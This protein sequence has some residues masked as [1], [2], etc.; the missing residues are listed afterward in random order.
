MLRLCYSCHDSFPSSDTNTQQIFWTLL[1]VSRLGVEI[2]LFVPSVQPADPS[3]PRAGIARYYGADARDLPHGF[4]LKV[5]RRRPAGSALAKGWFDWQAARHLARAS[6]DLVWTR[7]VLTVVSCIRAGLD[8]VFETYRPDLAKATRFALWRRAVIGNRHLRGVIAHSSLAA[9]AFSSAGVPA[10]R[11]LV[12]HNGFAPAVMEPMLERADARARLGLPDDRPL[13]VYTG[14][15]GRE[16]GTDA[17]LELAGAANGVRVV[18][19]GV[20]P[21]SAEERRTAD[22]IRRL[23]I[24]NVI[25][26]ARVPVFDVA[27]YLYAADCL[28]IPPTA[29]PLDRYGGTVLPMKVFMYLAAGRPILAPDLPDMREVLADGRTACLVPPNDIRSAARRLE[30]LLSDR[31]LQDRLSREARA[32][33][34]EHTW[35]ARARRIAGFLPAIVSREPDVGAS[36]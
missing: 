16:K 7:D 25:L 14:H 12:A 5:L 23:G 26:R 34:R 28:V 8:V 11:C 33:A 10:E 2:D 17:L 15:V 35:S 24:E 22:T 3:D 19:V 18:L 9:A 27:A 1:E 21:G 32:A 29:E 20:E 4:K 6:A 30:E 36:P 13:V 31:N